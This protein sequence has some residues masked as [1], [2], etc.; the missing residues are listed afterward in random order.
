MAARTKG[1]LRQDVWDAL[2]DEGVARFPFPPHGRIP[3]FEGS[4]E[5]AS[6][7]VE[8]E[9]F[10]GV[11]VAKINPDAP[12]RFVRIAALERGITVYVPTPRLRGGFYRLDPTDI[13]ADAYRKAASLSGMDEWAA[14]VSLDDLAQMDL[15]VT[16]SVAVSKE[17]HRCGKGEGY[18]DLEYA[19]LGA[20]GQEAVPIVTTV[21][22]LQVVDQVPAEEHDLVLSAIGV[23][24]TVL[25][26]GRSVQAPSPLDWSRLDEA[27]RSEMPVLQALWERQHDR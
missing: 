22:P 10:S 25:D 1:E 20:L 21:H 26:T 19:I 8:S 7:L 4:R 12:Q 27:N 16:G 2:E 13:P 24:D 6:R 9:W 17:G 3:N 14:T 23:P 11:D 18:S 15:I 5:A